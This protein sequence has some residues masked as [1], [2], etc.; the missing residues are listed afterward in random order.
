VHGIR[1]RGRVASDVVGS[2]SGNPF[3]VVAHLRRIRG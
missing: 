3:G 1:S 2:S